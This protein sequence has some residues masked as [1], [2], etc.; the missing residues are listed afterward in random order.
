MRINN[1]GFTLIELL[2][3]IIILSIIVAIMVPSVNYLIEKNKNDN[4]DNLKSSIL[5]AAKVY[6]SD[7]RYNITLDYDDYGGLCNSIEDTIENIA[8]I[9]GK[10]LDSN[11][12]PIDWLVDNKLLSTNSG[13]EIINPKDK[14][15]S[16]NL[17]TEKSNY[18]YVLIEYQCSTKDYTYKIEERLKGDSDDSLKWN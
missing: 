14:N 6:I 9:N 16:L 2:G 1:K 10:T 3:A 15:E 11:K 17:N 12:L 18:S 4:Y 13:G 7:N 5:S 8:S